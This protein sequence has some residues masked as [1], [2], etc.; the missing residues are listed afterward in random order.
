MSKNPFRLHF[1][2]HRFECACT[3]FDHNIRLEV[4]EE[5]GTISLSVPLNH[6][7]KWYA[8]IWIAVKF[9]F[10]I[11]ERYGH[12]DTEELN[13]D[14]YGRIRSL[15]DESERKLKENQEHV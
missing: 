10:G 6:W 2:F 5:M 15:L 14:D 13:P 7:R 4:D 3:T 1:S 12:Y 9:V 11:T 8:R